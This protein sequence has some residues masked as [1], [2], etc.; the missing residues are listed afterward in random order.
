MTYGFLDGFIEQG[1]VVKKTSLT[2]DFNYK[3]F[4]ASQQESVVPLF[5]MDDTG[6]VILI[7]ADAT[8]TPK[9]GQTLVTLARKTQPAP[10]PATA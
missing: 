6:Q 1:A 8:I 7:T 2:K 3:Q 5:I 10:A 9:P 4:I